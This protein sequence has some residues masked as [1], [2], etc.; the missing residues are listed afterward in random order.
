M[1]ASAIL[2]SSLLT[3]NCT[4]QGQQI[5]ALTAGHPSPTLW[6]LLSMLNDTQQQ[7]P[8]MCAVLGQ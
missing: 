8:S 2:T 7:Q 3:A 6:H 4:T 5:S 1:S